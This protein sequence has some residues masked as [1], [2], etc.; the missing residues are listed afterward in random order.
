MTGLREFARSAL[1]LLPAGRLKNRLLSGLGHRIHPSA[2]AE[3]NVVLRVTSVT[4]EAGAFL[5]RWNLIKDMRSVIVKENAAIGRMNLISSHPVY[6]RL[7]RDGAELELGV[8]AKIT[9]RHQLDCSGSLRIGAF[10]SIAGHETKV[11]SHS[12]DVRLDAQ[13]AYPVVIG[14]RSFVGARS[15]ILGGAALPD[16]SVLAA[17]STLI[18]SRAPGESGLWAGVPAVLRGPVSGRWFTRQTTGTT[19]VHV[20]STGETVEDAF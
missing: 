8:H 20:P 10:A 16:S 14:A 13:V 7:Y 3:P 9:S 11:L 19:R 15:L 5:G 1:W 6:K 17:G 2:R 4:L 12:I 18:R